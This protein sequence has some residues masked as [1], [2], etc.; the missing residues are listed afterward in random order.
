MKL[1]VVE[2]DSGHMTYVIDCVSTNSRQPAIDNRQSTIAAA[3]T[4]G[5]P[6]LPATTSTAVEPRV[7]LAS[8][9]SSAPSVATVIP[10]LLRHRHRPRNFQNN[11]AEQPPARLRPPPS[12][13]LGSSKFPPISRFSWFSEPK[14]LPPHI[15][16]APPAK[17][18]PPY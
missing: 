6:G 16:L 9:L 12:K 15:D 11:H 10:S 4:D 3:C 17:P 5:F 13:P 8:P 14:V 2:A 18:P 1:E 7:L